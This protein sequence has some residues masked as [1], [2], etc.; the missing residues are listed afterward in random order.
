M[1]L[2]FSHRTTADLADASTIEANVYEA[3][4]A[5]PHQRGTRA[6][7]DCLGIPLTGKR[8]SLRVAL[9]SR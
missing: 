4:L 3:T 5:A 8:S 9:T 6:T 2:P 7:R 1:G